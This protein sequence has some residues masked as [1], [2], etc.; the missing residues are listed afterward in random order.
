MGRDE[1]QDEEMVK[2][3]FAVSLE[4]EEEEEEEPFSMKGAAETDKLTSLPLTGDEENKEEEQEDGRMVALVVT[5]DEELLR[6]IETSGHPDFVADPTAYAEEA[7]TENEPDDKELT[8]IP[9]ED[10]KD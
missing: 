5:I 4:Q 7:S 9:E 3:T 10:D 8:G 6:R 1:E 2:S